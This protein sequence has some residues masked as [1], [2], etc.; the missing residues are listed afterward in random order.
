MI[1]FPDIRNGFDLSIE[2]FRLQDNWLKI[3][4]FSLFQRE[5]ITDSVFDEIGMM[6]LTLSLLFI[7]L[8]KRKVKTNALPPSVRRP[9]FGPIVSY[10]LIILGTLLIYGDTVSDLYVHSSFILLLLFMIKYRIEIYKFR[11][12]GND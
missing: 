5:I 9:L 3:P 1:L 7:C 8:A 11:R 4:V 10:A 6:G 2:Q 12:N